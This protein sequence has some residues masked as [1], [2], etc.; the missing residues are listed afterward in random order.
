MNSVLVID[1]GYQ[2]LHTVSVQHAI[3]MV[4]RGVA[5]ILETVE[6]RTIGTFAYPTVV[7]L[8]RVVSTA[9]RYKRPPAWSKRGVLQRDRFTCQ[10]CGRTATTVD[11][12]VPRSAGG[13]NDWLNTVAACRT[14]NHRKANRSPAQARM[15]LRTPPRVPSWD[16]LVEGPAGW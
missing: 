5:E 16:Q 6:G 10:Y 9:F 15:A 2:R 14:C 3:R 11:H 4:V 12:V 1:A 13:R 8:H 7:R